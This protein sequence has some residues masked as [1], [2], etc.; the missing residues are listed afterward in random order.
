MVHHSERSEVTSTST[1][2]LSGRSSSLGSQRR[3]TGKDVAPDDD[4]RDVTSDCVRDDMAAGWKG[5]AGELTD[6]L[7]G[8]DD[9]RDMAL[10]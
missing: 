3:E 9:E 5:T 8:L 4:R 7:E 6:E 10:L 1:A 2:E